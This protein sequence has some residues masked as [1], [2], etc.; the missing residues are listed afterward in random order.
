[1]IGP[2]KKLFRHTLI[3]GLGD[4]VVKAISFFLIPLYSRNLS[5][6]DF[7]VQSLLLTVQMILVI[8]MGLGLNSAVFKAYH[9]ARGEEEKKSAFTTA[10]ILL[11]LWAL[12]VW[13]LLSSL[14]EPVS[15]LIF[16]SG[17]QAAN[18]RFVF[19]GVLFDLFR[20]MGLALLRAREK[21]VHYG[22]VNTVHFTLL[23]V[24]NI[25]QVAFLKR[26]IAGI[27]ESQAIVSGFMALCLAGYL[28][29]KYRLVFSA[30]QARTLVGFGAPLVPGGIAGWSLTMLSWHLVNKFCGAHEIGVFSLGS[31]FGMI[32]NMLLV[33]PFRVAWLPFVFSMQKEKEARRLYTLTLTYVA[34]AGAV[35]FL[36]L[37]VFSR[38]I[39]L[40]A[41]KEEYLSG[42]RVIPFFALAFLFYGLYNTVDT[43]VVLKGRTRYHA[44]FTSIA[45]G[46][47]FCLNLILIPRFGS[48]GAAWGIL[49][50]YSALFFMMAAAARRLD[51]LPYEWGRILG[52]AAA[53]LLFYLASTFIRT[54]NP[55]LDAALK[56][57][58]IVLFPVF[59][60]IARFYHPQETAALKRA[61]AR[62]FIR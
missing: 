51:P 49:I 31:R 9:E 60:R 27:V 4:I 29:R 45:A 37:S 43:V 18:L 50:S 58:C 12:P 26:G 55:W 11:M 52:L 21:A 54:G 22:V 41:S 16:D 25:V 48:I 13:M 19:L 24:L 46:L 39:V 10:M 30:A 15:R 35:L 32:M 56:A 3:Y 59:L 53:T 28:F 47:Q 42:H 8:V 1:M 7:G 36:L 40:L 2:F 14:A 5:V 17:S 20:L 38:E 62:L 33:Q 23:L 57:L 61:A 44:L 6:E 34:A